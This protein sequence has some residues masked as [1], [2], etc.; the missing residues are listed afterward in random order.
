[1]SYD[2]I[3]QTVTSLTSLGGVFGHYLGEEFRTRGPNGPFHAL[4]LM[5]EG[6]HE[7]VSHFFRDLST[8]PRG[9]E[10][11]R[12][13]VSQFTRFMGNGTA[14]PGQA[15]TLLSE[16]EG[17]IARGVNINP[18]ATFPNAPR[19]MMDIL[20]SVRPNLINRFGHM[21]GVSKGLDRV[22]ELLSPAN[23]SFSA[24]ARYKSDGLF[25]AF[26]Q[27]RDGI[28]SNAA[29]NGRPIVTGGAAAGA[30]AIG[31]A[32][33]IGN[34]GVSALA[35]AGAAGVAIVAGAALAAGSVGVGVGCGINT[36]IG[37]PCLGDW[38][39]D[40]TLSEKRIGI[41]EAVKA[42]KKSYRTCE[43]SGNGTLCHN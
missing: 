30:S 20:H 34:M 25:R 32:M 16:A 13:A 37:E 9:G 10:A 18:S 35:S 42:E 19:T 5:A 43:P 2:G 3:T 8:Y 1:M 23:K 24:C 36:A 21:E 38:R 12:E 26:V 4:K 31:V 33:Q 28:Q 39:L 14:T 15:L 41:I 29:Q 27:L 40:P 6:S 17:V 11:W 7:G 22:E